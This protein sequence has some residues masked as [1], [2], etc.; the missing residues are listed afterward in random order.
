MNQYPS[1]TNVL[2][3]GGVIVWF[4]TRNQKIPYAIQNEPQVP[5]MAVA[6]ASRALYAH[7][8]AVNWASPPRTA[9][10][11]NRNRGD[12]VVLPYQ[13]ARFAATMNVAPA[14]LKRPSTLGAATGCRKILAG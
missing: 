11:G 6:S 4:A 2:P 3:A 10:N 13:P 7:T 14:K 12:V 1:G 9:A 8:P 5:C